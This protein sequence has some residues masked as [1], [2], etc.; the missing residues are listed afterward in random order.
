MFLCFLIDEFI[1][2][3]E[4]EAASD[5]E[6]DVIAPEIARTVANSRARFSKSLHY[7]LNPLTV[8]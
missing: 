8:N 2:L 6:C 4:G 7:L 3:R 5:K 1:S